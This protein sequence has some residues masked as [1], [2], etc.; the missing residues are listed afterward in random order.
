MTGI[1][2][3]LRVIEGSAFVAAP[4]G[5]MTL[6]Q[7]GADVIRFDPLGG[8][9]DYRRWPVTPSGRS[10]FWAGLNKGKRS[11]AIDIRSPEGQELVAA[12][13]C[14][15]GKGNG[16]F[17]SNFPPRGWLAY[18][19]LHLQR[20]DLIY[21]S[22][23]GDRHGGSAVDYTVNPRVGFPAITGPSDDSR[24]VNH[25]LPAWDNITGQMAAVGVLAAERHRLITGEGQHV[26][27]PLLD[28]A[29]A[30]V[31]HLGFIAEATVNG[32]ERARFG[33]H[34]YGGFGRDFQ[35]SDGQ[36]VMVVG[37]TAR[38]WSSI[39]N[40]TGLK[41]QIDAIGTRMDLDLKEEGNR[42][43]AREELSVVIG[44]WVKAKT[45]AEVS[46]VFNAN[47]VCW[48]V[49][50]NVPHLLSDDPEC[51][52]KNPLF[53][54]VV[55]PGIGEYLMPATPIDFSAV[56]RLPPQPA[57]ELGQHTDEILG[58]V[59]GLSSAQIGRLHD[60]GIIAGV[61]ASVLR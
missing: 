56:P 58:E 1:L 43:L 6:A 24:V 53:R 36:R 31:G 9:L 30:T 60:A 12:V 49:Y 39:V 26:R 35:T 34:L 32:A 52:E 50:Q 54:R 17:L 48:C 38:Q 41:E 44:G 61:R 55:Q 13:I 28:V 57:P 18:D 47:D 3:G 37:L 59:L 8:G 40:A 14:A 11:M 22:V 15:P 25:V 10:L 2:S 51:S 4:L 29:L 46:M 23:L 33:N 7:L 19:R 45:L 16:I 27:V 20:A 21:V 5:G 42:F